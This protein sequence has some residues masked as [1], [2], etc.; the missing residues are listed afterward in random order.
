MLLTFSTLNPIVCTFIV[1][2]PGIAAALTFATVLGV[3]SLNYIS[4]EIEMP[5]GDDPNDLPVHAHQTRFNRKLTTLL[6]PLA[7]H[8]PE[9]NCE[10][11]LRSA[12]KVTV[13]A[14]DT[15]MSHMGSMMSN[16]SGG[17]RTTMSP[18]D[19]AVMDVMI[20]S[21]SLLST[22]A[23]TADKLPTIKRKQRHWTT[24]NA[25]DWKEKVRII[26]PENVAHFVSNMDDADD[27]AAQ[28]NGGR[29]RW[30]KMTE[31]LDEE[32]VG[33]SSTSRDRSTNKTETL[34][35]GE[36]I[37]ICTLPQAVRSALGPGGITSHIRV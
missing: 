34:G 29:D 16:I 25:L 36:N 17:S 1:P 28:N 26:T 6:N 19:Q 7:Q 20:S 9:F 5:F 35:M 18:N 12:A 33:E 11:A 3:W 2:R 10:K 31:V 4:A 13:R 32:E 15:E 30:T 21:A 27:P 8:P 24:Q 37:S 22:G 14:D 23:S